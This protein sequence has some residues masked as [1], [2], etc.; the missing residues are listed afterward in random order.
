MEVDGVNHRVTRDEGMLRSPAPALVVATPVAVGDTVAAGASVLVLESMK[1]ETVL[2][3][4]FAGRVR[5]LLV[6]T[7]SQVETGAPML[8]IEPEAEEGAEQVDAATQ[9]G[10]DLEL[11]EAA[12]P[13]SA[14]ERVSEGRVALSAIMLG[15]DADPDSEAQTLAGYLSAREEARDAGLD[16]VTGEIELLCLFAELAELS[17]NRP[18]GEEQHTELRVHSSR[19]HFHTYLQSLDVERHGLNEHF[20]DRLTAVLARY[21]VTDLER[22]RSWR[23]RSSGSTSP[24][25]VPART[26]SWSPASCNGGSRSRPRTRRPATRSVSSST[27]WSGRPSCGS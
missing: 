14:A 4:P 1:M 16:V 3:A 22:T 17:R 27:G 2:Q 6:K 25:G 10:P 21:G 26:S 9:A 5:E 13:G 24:S 23:R 15:Y 11:P 8:R 18:G 20:R 19:E 7:G 12:R